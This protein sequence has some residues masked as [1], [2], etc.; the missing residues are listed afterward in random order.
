MTISPLSTELV[1]QG[2]EDGS[3]F[4]LPNVHLATY[5]FHEQ[6]D[7]VVAAILQ[8]GQSTVL[9]TREGHMR[10]LDESFGATSSN[11]FSKMPSTLSLTPEMADYSHQLTNSAVVDQEDSSSAPSAPSSIIPITQEQ[12]EELCLF[13]HGSLSYIHLTNTEINDLLSP[14]DAKESSSSSSSSSSAD[15]SSS[16]SMP[17]ATILNSGGIYEE[18]DLMATTTL[19]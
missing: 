8:N 17:M 2:Q 12:Q 11:M 14:G 15:V 6:V 1:N 18:T 10:L 7:P 19:P 5:Y 13:G 9:G 4:Q 3:N 16:S